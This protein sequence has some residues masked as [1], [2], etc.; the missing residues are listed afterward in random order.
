MPFLR[1]RE[2]QSLAVVEVIY[3]TLEQYDEI[4]KVLVEER[5][6]ARASFPRA[7]DRK[8]VKVK[9]L[10]DNALVVGW[11]D[12]KMQAEF[13]HV[14]PNTEVRMC[15][16]TMEWMRVIGIPFSAFGDICE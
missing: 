4:E 12:S 10:V 15:G 16:R 11:T 9:P 3:Q 5:K 13:H 2:L 1:T 7:K 8:K 6:K 14:S